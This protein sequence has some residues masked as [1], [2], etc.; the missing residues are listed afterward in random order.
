MLAEL[1]DAPMTATACLSQT[2]VTIALDRHAGGGATMCGI[3]G[4][5][6]RAPLGAD[7]PD[8]V[9]RA[10]DAMQH[11]GPDGFGDY[12]DTQG[13]RPHLYMAMRRLSIIDL[14]TG[15]QPLANEDQSVTVIVNGEIYNHVELRAELRARG[16][17]LR[18]GSDCEVLVHLYEDYD[19][20]FVHKLRGM[21]AFALWDTRKRRLVLGRDRLGEKPMYLFEQPERIRFASEMK[22]L[23]AMGEVP[24]SLDPSAV[25]DYLHY[26]WVPEPQTMVRGVRKLPP[27]NLLVIDVDAWSCQQLEYWRM[28]HAAPVIGNPSEL[29]R[30]ELEQIGTLIV[31]SDVPVGIALSGGIDSSLTAA[32]AMRHSAAPLQAFTVGYQGTPGQD[33]RPMART[34]AEDLG[35]PFRSI[36]V[37]TSGMVAAFPQVVACRDDPIADI[38]GHGYYVLSQQARAHGCPVLIQGQGGDELFWGYPWMVQAVKH[39]LRK[40]AGHPVGLFEALW[41]NRP[42]GLSR[43]DLARMAYFLGGLLAGWRSLS[44]GMTSPAEQLVAYDL[45]DSYQ[46]ATHAVGPTY[47][48]RFADQLAAAAWHPRELFR[49]VG[50][51]TPIDIQ[52]IAVLC[53]GFLLQNGLAQGDRLSMA[54]SVELR[55]PLVD[56]RLV[57]LAIGLQKV[58]PMYRQAPKRALRE[59]AQELLPAYVFERPKRG[60]NPPVVH[61]IAALKAAYGSELRDGALVE[62]ELLDRRAAG[63]LCESQSRFGTT[64][65]LF[66]KYLVL[67]YWYRGMHAVARH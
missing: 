60:F 52:I 62:A 54:N 44:P 65:D 63:R 27:G 42:R 67:E 24:L 8:A 23:L 26:G 38:A 34:L 31:R 5:A 13:K 37:S 40:R 4:L 7:E 49:C 46:A 18:T 2:P 50:D 10:A 48:R 1:F 28:E 59:A 32:M 17:A 35:L 39:S 57:E 47:T 22:A 30:A 36:E 43:P 19:L 11:R 16:H 45:M 56:Y 14:T 55:L 9:R 15:W 66:F 20:E 3:A 58:E 61:W 12:T 64:N 41:A 33:E 21:F 51:D 25:H 29:L 53:R 6:G